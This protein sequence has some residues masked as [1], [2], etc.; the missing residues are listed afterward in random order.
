MNDKHQKIYNALIGGAQAGLAGEKLFRL[1]LEKCPKTTSKKIVRASLMALSDPDVKDKKILE[2][3][4]ALAIKHRLEPLTK[5]ELKAA[6][7]K[8]KPK[9]A[10][11]T[12]E[13]SGSGESETSD[14]R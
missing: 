1:V 3:V 6:K 7:D 8:P 4:C 5:D 11:K 2:V 9:K 13:K 14:K 12:A 10:K